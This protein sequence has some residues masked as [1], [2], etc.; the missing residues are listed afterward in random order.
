MTSNILD[1]GSTGIVA[2]ALMLNSATASAGPCAAEVIEFQDTLPRDK[3]GEFTFAGA[4][5]QSIDAQLEH[6]PTPKSVER[7]KKLSRDRI[8]A[9]LAQAKALISEGKWIECRG[10]MAEA[11]LLFSR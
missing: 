10:A 3:N 2:I 7:A 6:Q 5:P 1:Y 8:L 4:A 9:V 11:K